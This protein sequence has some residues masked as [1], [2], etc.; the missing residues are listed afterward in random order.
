MAELTRTTYRTGGYDP[1]APDKNIVAEDRIEYDDTGDQ[2]LAFARQRM[3]AVRAKA[4]AIMADP[5]NAT[6]WTVAERK[7]I[8]AALVLDLARRTV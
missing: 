2:E 7:V 4:R 5:V 3:Q 6:D 8:L 1:A